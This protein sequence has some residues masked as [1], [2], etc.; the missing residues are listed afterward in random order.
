MIIDAL[1]LRY[2]ILNKKIKE[3]DEK[4][5]VI[6]N[7]YGQRYIG[8]GAEKKNIVIE[9]TAGNATGAYL[10]NTDIRIK[11]NA[12]DAIGDTM[13]DGKIVIEGN[14]GDATG[15]GARGGKIYIRGNVGYRAGIHM[16]AYKE[17]KP[18]LIIGERAGSF[19]GEYQAGGFI[20]VLNLSDSE[21]EIFGHFCATGMHGGKMFFR[22][23]K[24]PDIDNSGL[25][26][27]KAEKEDMEE[28]KHYLIEYCELLNVN[29]NIIRDNY[30][31][32]MPNSINPYKKIYTYN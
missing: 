16:K 24:A 18:V 23:E 26:I 7:V 3:S 27:R 28:I 2:D 12:Q 11:G 8:T 31:I 6:K 25:T 29:K 4:D 5:I 19:L 15:Y 32:V 14:S 20:F 1:K 22:T 30:Y 10:T 17:K 9:G 21:E 13:N